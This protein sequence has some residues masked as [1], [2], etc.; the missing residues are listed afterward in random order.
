MACRPVHES[1]EFARTRE[2]GARLFRISEGTSQIQ[3]VIIAWQAL[4]DAARG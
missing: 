1:V 2:Q 3:Q 4:G